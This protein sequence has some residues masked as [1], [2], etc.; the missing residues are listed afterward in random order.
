MDIYKLKEAR[1]FLYGNRLTL[2]AKAAFSS[3]EIV[4]LINLHIA[5]DLTIELKTFSFF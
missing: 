2:G 5:L 4:S 3:L 1:F